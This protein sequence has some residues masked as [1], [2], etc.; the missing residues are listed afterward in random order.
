[1]TARTPRPWKRRDIQHIALSQGGLF[2]DATNQRTE[3]FARVIVEKSVSRRVEG[4]M[5]NTPFATAD[6]QCPHVE[7]P[8]Q[9]QIDR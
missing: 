9:H 3:R 4:P 6:L 1:M 7:R 2:H 8:D 5:A